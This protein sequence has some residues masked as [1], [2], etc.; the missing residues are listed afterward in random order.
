MQVVRNRLGALEEELHTKPMHIHAKSITLRCMREAMRYPPRLKQY[1]TELTA[2][3]SFNVLTPEEV[4]TAEK[5]LLNRG[6][7]RDSRAWKDGIGGLLRHANYYG[8]EIAKLLLLMAAA[9]ESYVLK[10]MTQARVRNT[11]NTARK[12]TESPALVENIMGPFEQH[13]DRVQELLRWYGGQMIRMYAKREYKRHQR[14]HSLPLRVV[15]AGR[16]PTTDERGALSRL[17]R[18]LIDLVPHV[19]AHGVVDPPK[20]PVP[21]VPS[22]VPLEASEERGELEEEPGKGGEHQISSFQLMAP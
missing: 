9:A 17:L 10:C 15:L 18:A 22:P 16:A 6:V 8:V 13:E 2:G 11:I 19:A 4:E 20:L 7:Q 1:V 5:I 3:I 12:L 14:L 21:P